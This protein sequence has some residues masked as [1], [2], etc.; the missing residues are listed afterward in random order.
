MSI[1]NYCVRFNRRFSITQGDTLQIE[2]EVVTP[3]LLEISLQHPR[4]QSSIPEWIPFSSG[5]ISTGQFTVLQSS[6]FT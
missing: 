3:A 4:M 6:C 5:S 2:D 1:F